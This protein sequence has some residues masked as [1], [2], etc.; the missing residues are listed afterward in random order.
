MSL[1][2]LALVTAATA[3]VVVGMASSAG[4]QSP[5]RCGPRA[6]LLKQLSSLYREQ[7]V[8]LGIADTG[9]LLEVVAA[10][11]GATWTVIVTRSNGTSCVIMTGEGWQATPH[12][13]LVQ[14]QK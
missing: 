13:N 9:T 6:E 1:H 14:L 3:A 11:D 7:P 12:Q 5:V 8:A 10:N 4:A 2:R